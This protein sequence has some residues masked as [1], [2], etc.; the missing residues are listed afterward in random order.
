MTHARLLAFTTAAL[1]ALAGCKMDMNTMLHKPGSGDSSTADG[2]GDGD[3]DGDSTDDGDGDGGGGGG[4]TAKSDICEHIEGAEWDV[5]TKRQEL[6]DKTTICD[7]LVVIDPAPGVE[8]VKAQAPG[9]CDKL[10][11]DELATSRPSWAPSRVQSLKEG[12]Y[13]WDGTPEI[14]GAL[15]ASPDD[16]RVQEQT[17]YFYQWWVNLTG[18]PTDQLDGLFRYFGSF[19]GKSPTGGLYETTM[20]EACKAFPRASEEASE[21]DQVLAEVVR[22]SIG[23]GETSPYWVSHTLTKEIS[24]YFDA[25]A[26]PP[27][28]L[29]RSYV[30]LSCLGD[31][32]PIADRDLA[33]YATCGAD[34]RALDSA[35]LEKEIAKY[36]E[37]AKANVRMQ[38]AAARQVAARYEEVAQ[39]KVKE[40]PAWQ[41][42]IYDAPKTAW[43]EWA[44]LYKTNKKAIDAARA[45]ETIYFGASRKAAK[46]CW[47]TAWGNL[48]A[49]VATKKA[50][51]L[52]DAKRAM[53]DTV[54]AIILEHL[55]ACADSEGEEM[56]HSYFGQLFEHARPARGPRYASLFA[57]IDTLNEIK[58]DR[59]KFPAEV[60]WFSTMYRGRSPV[61]HG[62]GG[63]IDSLDLARDDQGGV[64]KKLEKDGDGFRVEYKTEK[65]KESNYD[66]KEN[67]RI[68][69]FRIDGSPIYG[70]DCVYKGEHWVE[71]THEAIWIPAALAGTIKAGSF[72]RAATTS[73]RHGEAWNAIPVEVWANKD[74]EKLTAYMGVSL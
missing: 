25:A 55:V 46:G 14:L 31:P 16:A 15:C 65:W 20:T 3:G 9:W 41:T 32:D 10:S 30:V 2:N 6:A 13:W 56:M 70:Q 34:A 66:C 17:A 72:V 67:S 35:K 33:A 44:A 28:E 39:A 18:L 69:Q 54:G 38:F 73:N 26:E 51:T 52:V 50:K 7:D 60:E 61:A 49:H 29:I 1:A 43:Q 59:S 36:H 71:Q 8:R 68:I 22:A 42:L 53:T 24:W 63:D 11:K 47:A 57:I 48:E 58:E 74:R 5:N 4:V 37:L 12:R 64:V 40:D 21:H 19:P 62:G 27:S 23:C 45:Y